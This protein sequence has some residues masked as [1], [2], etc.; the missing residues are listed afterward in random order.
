SQQVRQQSFPQSAVRTLQQIFDEGSV[1]PE[2][3]PRR[4]RSRG[5]RGDSSDRVRYIRSGAAV[6]RRHADLEQAGRSKL[7]EEEGCSLGLQIQIEGNAVEPPAEIGRKN[8]FH[9]GAHRLL[10]RFRQSGIPC[11]R[12]ELRIERWPAKIVAEIAQGRE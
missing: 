8:R 12:C 5:N 4:Q 1:A 10:G 7:W 3:E 11:V 2:Y 9:D 6:P